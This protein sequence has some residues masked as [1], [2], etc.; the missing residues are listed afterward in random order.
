M[1]EFAFYLCSNSS[2]VFLLT[3]PNKK[4]KDQKA[5]AFVFFEP[6]LHAINFHVRETYAIIHVSKFYF[7]GG[8]ELFPVLIEKIYIRNVLKKKLRIV[9]KK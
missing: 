9:Y 4:V 7:S 8:I 5:E 3:N 6:H 1:S 2:Q